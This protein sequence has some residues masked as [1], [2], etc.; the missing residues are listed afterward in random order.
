MERPILVGAGLA[1]FAGFAF[2]VWHGP[3]LLHAFGSSRPPSEEAPIEARETVLETPASDGHAATTYR[4]IVF[5]PASAWT[6]TASVKLPAVVFM[7]GWGGR[8]NASNVIPR[9]IASRDIIVVA[10]DDVEHDLPEAGE[11][12]DERLAR[13]LSYDLAAPGGLARFVRLADLK[14]DLA[15]AKL[16][17]VID[18]VTAGRAKENFNPLGMID[19]RHIAVVGYSFGGTAATA[20]LHV[21]PRISAAVN[22]D[23]WLFGKNSSSASPRPYLFFAST[24][25]L[26]TFGLGA[27]RKNTLAIDALSEQRHRAQLQSAASQSVIVPGSL[28]GDLA[29]ELYSGR[30]W[31]EWRP[32]KTP[33]AEARS[34]RATIDKELFGFLAAHLK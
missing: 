24:N 27:E 29:D 15:A 18:A 9:R 14:A 7:P 1:L 19:G 6:G 17:R 4:A 28:H 30:R 5:A 31:T 32:W 13:L 23:G 20:A 34:V 16:S 3:G 22:I 26:P 25:S 10:V 11:S 21:E 2:F 33:L 12:E 8:A